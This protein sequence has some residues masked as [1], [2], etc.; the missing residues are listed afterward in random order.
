MRVI[1]RPYCLCSECTVL[2][3]DCLLA[4]SSILKT[5]QSDLL[6][7]SEELHEYYESSYS[8]SLVRTLLEVYS[9]EWENQ[10][11]V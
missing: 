8:D 10:K 1:L 4:K 7:V 2:V 6:I 5:S 9:I 11:F 3:I